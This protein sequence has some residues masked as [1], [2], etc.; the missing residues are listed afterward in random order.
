MMVLAPMLNM[1]STVLMKQSQLER[2]A[3]EL[4][5]QERMFTLMGRAIQIAGYRDPLAQPT[6]KSPATILLPFIIHKAVG[7]NASD[8]LIIHHGLPR[9]ASTKAG[10]EVNFDCVGNPLT[11][12]RTQ[13]GQVRLGFSLDRQAQNS[14]TG[15]VMC[16][17]F[18]R[19]GR[20]QKTTLMTGIEQMR[21][22]EIA[23][24]KIQ[25]ELTIN[26]KI[27]A[28]TFARRNAP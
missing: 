12:E 16:E 5:E 19:Q 27:L 21:F 2:T 26:K 18:D 4:A 20:A 22:H 11:A 9:N 28:R 14:F 3:L 17:S 24:Q 7:F 10:D 6:K 15:S 23:P 8:K 13:A 1:T 25:I